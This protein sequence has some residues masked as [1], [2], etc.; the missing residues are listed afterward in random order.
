[1]PNKSFT[2]VLLGT[3]TQ[4]SPKLKSEPKGASQSVIGDYLKGETLSI[5]ASLIK[6]ENAQPEPN[7]FSPYQCNEVAVI[8][9]P[10]TKGTDVGDKIAQG[11][12]ASLN[13]IARGQTLIN[14]I[15]HSRGV[16]EAILIAHEL[17]EI[18]KIIGTCDNLEQVL[19]HLKA[20]K[21][22]RTANNTPP[23]TT[24]LKSLL[25]PKEEQE[26]WFNNLKNNLP[27]T[28]INLFG[29]D[30][31][32]GDFFPYT[33]YDDRSFTIPPIIKNA[34]FIY[35]AN[36]RSASAFTPIY[37]EQS[38]QEQKIRRRPMPGHHGTGSNGNNS[39]QQN[40]IVAPVGKKST[41]VQKL[42]IY[43][44]LEF[45]TQHH[46]EFK[47]NP[48]IFQAHRAL[49]KKYAAMLPGV[50]YSADNI[51]ITQ[52][53][54]PEIY[55]RLYNRIAKNQA[56]YD[57][58][59]QTNY[60]YTGLLI[61]QRKIQ[62]TGNVQ[63][64][65]NDVFPSH[66][67]YANEEHY[68][69]MQEYFLKFLQLDTSNSLAAQVNNVNKVL[70]AIIKQTPDA[71]YSDL[72]MSTPKTRQDFLDHF[73]LV[74]KKISLQYLADDW[75][76]AEKQPEKKELF[77][78]LIGLFTTFTELTNMK[79]ETVQFFVT[80]LIKQSK[81]GITNTIKQ[82]HKE[83]LECFANLKRSPFEE[84]HGDRIEDFAA[85]HH[86]IQI[87]INE[88]TAL[89]QLFPNEKAVFNYYELSLHK[90]AQTLIQ[91][92]AQRFYRDEAHVLPELALKGSFQ[93]LAERYAINNYNVQDRILEENARL[94]Q[95]LDA[96]TKEKNDYYTLLNTA[97][98]SLFWHPAGA[99]AAT[100]RP[101]DEDN[102]GPNQSTSSI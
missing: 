35:Y 42:I 21:V 89:E 61:T 26:A 23:I 5:I 56:A 11:L 60:S 39:S 3:N 84:H 20:Q 90:T 36:E 85:L 12:T 13:A 7:N 43:N 59:N 88:L 72:I 94:K 98:S 18:Q 62:H 29:I 8:N 1:M 53:N 64:F 33:W 54:Y 73:E 82:Q 28:S 87:V 14:M 68:N 31:V 91:M 48:D 40:K 49:G 44:L 96:I 47:E 99:N 9:G 78:T 10:V 101:L 76:H 52:L 30:P 75:S 45:L 77:N 74:V 95:Q 46:V 6:T 100:S 2:L 79:D 71:P 22:K 34:D 24:L 38:S 102:K 65:F 50:E 25:P 66:H 51:N 80:E 27:A 69:L 15:A 37:S 93:E 67:G 81:L 70:E 19:E 41:H 97:K 83:L 92:A 57:A 4:Y 16:V 63:K 17:E 86:K 32:P 58:F 55:R